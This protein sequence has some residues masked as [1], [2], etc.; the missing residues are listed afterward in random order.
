MP[1][2]DKMAMYVSW[3]RPNSLCQRFTGWLEC[4]ARRTL[5]APAAAAVERVAT[6][7]SGWCT[8]GCNDFVSG[9]MTIPHPGTIMCPEIKY[10]CDPDHT[11]SHARPRCITHVNFDHV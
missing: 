1:A 11:L 9:E 10:L 6:D 4:G 5:W 8:A 2:A 7:S 3:G